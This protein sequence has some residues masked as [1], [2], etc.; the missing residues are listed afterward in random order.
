MY[1]YDVQY[2]DFNWDQKKEMGPID[3]AGAITAFRSFPFQ[4][5]YEKALSISEGEL[6]RLSL[7]GHN[8]M[9][10]LSPYGCLSRMF[11]KYF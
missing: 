2:G 9:R 5:E 8:P 1:T 11:T 10:R 4:E 6:L 3:V 7:T